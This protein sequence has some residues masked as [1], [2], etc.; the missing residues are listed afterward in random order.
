MKYSTEPGEMHPDGRWAGGFAC[1]EAHRQLLG[2]KTSDE[3]E[4]EGW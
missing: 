4:C 2:G 1:Q 3:S